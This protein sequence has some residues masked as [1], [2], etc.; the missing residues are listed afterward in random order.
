MS[1]ATEQAVQ[2]TVIEVDITL[3]H[4][5]PT[6]PRTIKDG[7]FRK[8]VKSLKEFP[9]MLWK[10][11]PVVVTQEDGSYMALGGNKR[12]DAARSAGY[13]TIPIMVADDWDADQRKRFILLDNDNSG[14]W[15]F[16]ML[17]QQYSLDVIMDI[18]SIQIPSSLLRGSSSMQDDFTPPNLNEVVTTIKHG[19]IIEIGPHRLV[20]GDCGRED[21]VDLLMDGRQAQAIV[22]DPPY[23]VDYVGGT[24]D[25]HPVKNDSKKELP[26]LLQRGFAQYMRIARPGCP[27][28]V[29]HAAGPNAKIFWDIIGGEG[30]EIRQQLIWVKDAA[31]MGH[32]DY[33][34]RH[35][36]IILCYK[37][38]GKG[39]LGRG[40][41]AWEGG[42]NQN[43]VLEF[44]RP[45][46]NADHATEKPVDLW[47]LLIRNHS[48][49]DDIVADF[50][51]GSGTTM[52]ACHDLGRV[53][54]CMEKEPR[55]CQVVVDRMKALDPSLKVVHHK[56]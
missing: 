21:L 35:E 4:A 24:K 15:D 51:V 56:A 14:D 47:A 8:L 41:D 3:V 12:T 17:T 7:A 34:Y 22:T 44:P 18:S 38:G 32:S 50:F 5:N 54:Y 27:V 40:G 31:V 1:N 26:E 36:P 30:F 49:P 10:R 33:H 39:R 48:H 25:K 46:R 2:A 55:C 23:G 29:S 28:Y 16:G 53:A 13:K 37:P 43:T 42:N 45:K 20:C 6:N 9:Q 52:V 19:D 11:P